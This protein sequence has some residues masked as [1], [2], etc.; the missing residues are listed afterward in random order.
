MAS[1]HQTANPKDS[2]GTIILTGA[3]GSLGFWVAYNL[4]RSY[5]SY[6]AILTVRNDS[7]KDDNTSKLREMASTV[8][9]AQFSIEAVD[10]ASLSNVRLFANSVTKRISSGKLPPISAVI[11]NA[12]NWSLDGQKN[13]LDGLD[14][15]FQVS[16]LSHFLLVLKLLGS[17]DINT[18]RIVLI[19]SE[20]HDSKNTNAFNTLGAGLPENLEELV[21][22]TADKPGKELA[23]GFQRYANAKLA[24]VMFMHMLNGK[25]LEV[26]IFKFPDSEDYK[27]TAAEPIFE[28]H[29]SCGYKSR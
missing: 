22:P 24:T 17:M 14:L 4:L 5:P 9:S 8:K 12:F 21:A 26:W 6:F 25:L 10:L 28:A 11:C 13:S 19:G 16:H 18:G 15:C 7:P 29:Y 1:T 3:N 23:R 2:K 20:A 27:L